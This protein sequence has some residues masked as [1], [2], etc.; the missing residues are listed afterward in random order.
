MTSNSQNEM[1]RSRGEL[2]NGVGPTQPE[3]IFRP[4]LV[5]GLGG[6]GTLVLK[7]LKR[8]IRNKF[9]HS[10]QTELFQLLAIDTELESLSHLQGLEVTEFYNLA[11]TTIRGNDVIKA[12]LGNDTHEIYKGLRSWW[13]IAKSGEPFKPGDITHGAK[14][15]RCI[16][17]LAFWSRGPEVRRRIERKITETLNIRGLRRSEFSATGTTMKVFIVCSLAG[18]TG[19]GMFLDLTYLVRSVLAEKGITAFITG[20][21]LIDTSPFSEVIHEEGLLRRMEANIY[22]SLCEIDWLMGGHRSPEVRAN[23][24]KG[25][26]TPPPAT[27]AQ[28]EFA[29]PNAAQSAQP[30]AIRQ[31]GPLYEMQ[32]HDHLR[33][34]SD[35]R[36]FDVCYLVTGT[37]ENA[38]R[39]REVQ[40][41]TEMIA[42]E[43]FLEI[44]TPLGR[45]GRSALDNIERLTS[46]SEY[47]A[48]PLAFSSFA[49]ASLN[50]SP[51][52]V[53]ER[54]VLWLM[55]QIFNRLLLTL[56]T[57]VTLTGRARELLDQ[58]PLS[59]DQIYRRITSLVEEGQLVQIPRLSYTADADGAQ[60]R[61]EAQKMRQR[62]DS[63]LT[64]AQTTYQQ[65]V[66]DR[67]APAILRSLEELTVQLLGRNDLTL[68]QVGKQIAGL[69]E[70]VERVFDDAGEQ[71]DLAAKDA[72]RTDATV[73]EDFAR[74]DRALAAPSR[75]LLFLPT[76]KQDQVRLA[77]ET[78]PE[79]LQRYARFRIEYFGWYGVSQLANRVRQQLRAYRDGL[80][81]LQPRLLE[82]LREV[83]KELGQRQEQINRGTHQY[84]LEFEALD[85]QDIDRRAGEL[86]RQLA[87][88]E[89]G[90]SVLELSSEASLGQRLTVW[91]NPIARYLNGLVNLQTNMTNLPSVLYELYSTD[92]PGLERQLKKLVDYAEPFCQLNSTLSPE[93]DQCSIISLVGF[94]GAAQTGEASRLVDALQ[95]VIDKF[96]RV[97]TGEPH[98]LVYLKTKHGLPLFAVAL[99]NGRMRDAYYLYRRGWERADPTFRPVHS[100]QQWMALQDFNPTPRDG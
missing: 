89:L 32:Y 58:L 87:A 74:L 38:R 17:R 90:R 3:E 4:T 64:T 11:E 51:N 88:S 98:R 2:G 70:Q 60:L 45:T 14:A 63:V 67:I 69:L 100:D 8:L 26:A 94:D 61:V 79:T 28:E 66:D 54:T 48:R 96:S 19:S 43:V 75:Q 25:T 6:T 83:R 56:D 80:P 78:I 30:Q 57:P 99:T 22:A 62:I 86:L 34:S 53:R 55:E 91:E 31:P 5:V 95:K 49:V 36:P 92:G 46:V 9:Q 29:W 40:S 15:T 12:M 10:Q 35:E 16:G 24:A 33:V 44:A 20:L 39:L 23:R 52:L 93:V 42:Q 47:S 37:N 82:L 84:Q 7:R 85:V 21:L 72:G 65:L 81:K 18:G 76:N 1:A 13:P 27:S 97:D 68:D 71:S 77:A 41:I 50:L 73:N 59:S